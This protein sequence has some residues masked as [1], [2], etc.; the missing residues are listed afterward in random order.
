[1][2]RNLLDIVEAIDSFPYYA[3]DTQAYVTFMQDFYYF[4]IDEYPKPLGYVHSSI[5][6][7]VTWPDCW[8]IDPARRTLNLHVPAGPG[9]PFEMRTDLVNDTVA[10]AEK[11]G[12]VKEMTWK[13]EPMAVYTPDGQ[14]VFNM[15]NLGS[16]LLGVI[17]FGVHLIAWTVVDGKKLYW[18]QRRSETRPIH[19]GKLD[20]LAGGGIK[21][22]EP[23]IDAMV[24][25]AFEE[26]SIPKDF[27]TSHLRPCG[28]V[29]YHLSYSHLNNPG[30][31]PHALHVFEME[32]PA[33]M[34]P[35]PND[36]EVSEFVTMTESEVMAAL[37]RDDFKPIV[38]IQWVAHFCRT[39]ALTLENEPRLLEMCARTHRNLAS[40]VV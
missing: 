13:G 26:A 33:D 9:T 36:G 29:S 25:E 15:D 39:G 21:V 40:F 35:K 37:F 7:N 2:S 1:M 19:P 6:D 14:H 24:R 8:T 30:S 38:G 12:K 3:D 20:T 11:E 5:I 17:S 4:T 34:I 10:R 18:L 27:S 16:Q 32:L 28:I 22:G 23:I 31:F